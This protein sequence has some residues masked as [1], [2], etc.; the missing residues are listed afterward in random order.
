MAPLKTFHL[1][2]LPPSLAI[3]IALYTSLTNALFLRSQLLANDPAFEY[4]LIDATTLV[5]TTHLLAA[6]FRAANDYLNKRLKS[7]N[8]HSEIVFSLGASNNIAQSLRGFGIAD[9]TT[10]LVVVKVATHEGVDREGV[11]K[12]LEGMVEGR[13][14][15]FCD[16]VLRVMTD[17]AKV[18]NL[19][20]LP[21]VGGEGK[22]QSKRRRKDG[23]EEGSGEV[24]GVGKGAEWERRELEVAILGLMAL[25]GAV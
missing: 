10:E 25:R 2:H 17:V 8:V 20:K 11:V 13:E 18:R 23:S 1:T 6:T 12:H 3:H 21:L 24:L 5:S 14:V 19:Y 22:G 15:E 9:G 4:A 16:E 7:R